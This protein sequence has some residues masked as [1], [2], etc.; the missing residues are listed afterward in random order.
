MRHDGEEIVNVIE[1]QQNPTKEGAKP[2]R[3]SKKWIVVIVLVSFAS[4]AIFSY[5]YIDKYRPKSIAEEYLKAVQLHDI[6]KLVSISSTPSVSDTLLINLINWKFIDAKKI[7][8]TKERLDLSEESFKDEVKDFLRLNKKD[9]VEDLPDFLKDFKNRLKNYDAWR[10]D[11]IKTHKAFEENGNYY[12]YTDIPQ[13]EY[14]LD[15]TAT[16][17]LGMEL[18]KKYILLVAK[19]SDGWKVKEFRER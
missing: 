19:E 16:N 14:L 11:E 15:I 18:R 12:Y 8:K 9:S 7:S 4:I 2:T 1:N 6:K 3:L 10:T 5:L 13:I 17:R